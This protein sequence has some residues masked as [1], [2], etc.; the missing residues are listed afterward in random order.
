M[1]T[2]SYPSQQISPKSSQFKLKLNVACNRLPIT[3]LGS[4]IKLT[5]HFNLLPVHGILDDHGFHGRLP[6]VLGPRTLACGGGGGGSSSS[7]SEVCTSA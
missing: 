5:T 3:E 6:F 4:W 7:T 2:P 1:S